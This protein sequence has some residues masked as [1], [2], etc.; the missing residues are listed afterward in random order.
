[1]AA[2]V[3]AAKKAGEVWR[4]ASKKVR[5]K[6]ESSAAEQKEEDEANEEEEGII[7]PGEEDGPRA[8]Q[9]RRSCPG[10]LVY[11]VAFTRLQPSACSQAQAAGRDPCNWR[12]TT[13]GEGA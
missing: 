6:E 12:A 13:A 3:V 9:R 4:K 8:V 10:H 5:F 7:A 2:G 11:Y 1:M